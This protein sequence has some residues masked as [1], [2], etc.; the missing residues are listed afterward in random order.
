VRRAG[1]GRL[2]DGGR[3]TWTVADGSKGRRWREV[4]I[5]GSGIR[6]SLLFE[7]APDRRFSHLELAS[8]AGLLTLHPEADGTLHGNVVGADGVRHVIGLPWSREGLVDLAGSAVTTAAS[9]WLLERME[10]GPSAP[11]MVLRISA[12]L[13]LDAHPVVV[14]RRWDGSWGIA[15]ASRFAADLD[16]LPV[17]A[18]GVTWPLEVGE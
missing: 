3:V 17:L 14:A 7:T 2:P 18:D 10:P 11:L 16:G 1:S 13:A 6:H 5:E 15:G 4:V 8:P 9:A 12:A